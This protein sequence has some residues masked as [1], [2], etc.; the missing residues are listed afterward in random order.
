MGSSKGK[1]KSDPD[2]PT[3]L[4]DVFFRIGGAHVGKA[5][6][7]LVVNSSNV[8]LDDIWAWRADHGTGVGWTVNTADTGVVVNGDNVTAYGL[9]VEHYQKTET[10][11]NGNGGTVIFFQNE[12]PYDSPS[13][14]AW[15]A[16]P[17]HPGFPA[18]AVANP[19]TSFA[20]YSMG[21]YS[22]FNQG[23]DIFSANAFE[24]PDT[25]AAGSLHDLLTIFLDAVNGKGGILNVVNDTGG[26]ST[27]ANPGVPVTVVSYP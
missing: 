4:S 18:L 2:D 3:V 21:S 19:V 14:A 22:F 23:V 26:S 25:L 9:F 10:I 11:W 6:T 13:Q 8:I 16:S 27:V 1:P 17:G 7:S 20:G 5:T 12:M 24:V 15:S